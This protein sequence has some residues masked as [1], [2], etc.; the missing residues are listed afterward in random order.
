MIASPL[1]IVVR[2]YKSCRSLGGMKHHHMWRLGVGYYE[3][4]VFIVH[5]SSLEKGVVL[6]RLDHSLWELLMNLW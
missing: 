4:F 2:G 3:L 5:P 6:G 1:I